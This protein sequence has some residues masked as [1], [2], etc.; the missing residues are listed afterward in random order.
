MNNNDIVL[1]AESLSL[2]PFRY[3]KGSVLLDN[4]VIFDPYTN[5]AD[6]GLV[7]EALVKKCEEE[8]LEFKITEGELYIGRGNW[9]GFEYEFEGKFSQE[10]ICQAYLSS[11]EEHRI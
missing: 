8:S 2:K 6:T 11:I 1:I 7:L 4:A 10:S 5:W 9:G 3:Y